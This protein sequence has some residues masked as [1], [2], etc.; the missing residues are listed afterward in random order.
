MHQEQG[1]EGGN[2][3][4][5]R[6]KAETEIAPWVK[7][8]SIAIWVFIVISGLLLLTISDYIPHLAVAD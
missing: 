5:Q 6:D 8:T 4:S 3:N 1:P 7:G 2:D